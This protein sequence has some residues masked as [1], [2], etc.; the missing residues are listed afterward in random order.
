MGFIQNYDAL[1]TT[2][3]RKIVLGLIETA[4]SSIQPEIILKKNFALSDKVLKVKNESINLA[5][6]E[7]IFLIGFG[8]GSARISAIIEKTLGDLLTKGFVIDV[9]K[10]EFSKIEFTLGTHPLPSQINF[11]FTDKLVNQFRD[12]TAKDLIIVVTCGGGSALLE[13]PAFLSLA[14]SIDIFKQLLKSGANINQMNVVRKHLSKVK[15]G[16]L[17]TLL[18]PATIYNLV[19]SDVP[20]NDLS[21]IASG[22]LVIDRS[23][24]DEAWQII[25][26]FN[27]N[28]SF[29]LTYKIFVETPKDERYFQR[30][31]HSIV[32][33]NRT[34]LEAMANR[35]RSIRKKVRIF[36]DTFQGEA[37]FAGKTL[38]ENT[39]NNS[40]L[41]AAGET[42]VKVTGSGK[43]GRNQELV[44]GS[45]RYLTKDTLITSFA[46]DGWDNIEAAGAI[47]DV[48]TIKKAQDAGIEP[49]KFLNDN[50]SLSFFKAVSDAILTGRLPTNISDLIIVLRK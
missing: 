24:K 12:V 23:T 37:K 41:L 9:T 27:L 34:A 46:S 31:K 16:G 45:L 5:D 42:T 30:I 43:G 48:Q 4:Y 7:R 18:Y 22:P 10:E 1:A 14:Q 17:A 38:I 39:N 49:Q 21:T 11:D 50:D 25:E 8:K 44:L 33:S 20:G 26:Q 15:G 36:T 3:E 2:S 35:A 32:L 40:I 47:G 28:K 13:Q 19:F 29:P 6:F